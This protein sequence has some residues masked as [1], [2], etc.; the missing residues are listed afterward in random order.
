MPKP[1]AKPTS[2][3]EKPSRVR[4]RMDEAQ[5]E[6]EATLWLREMWRN[7]PAWLASAII[8][9]AL[10]ILLA[11]VL[12]VPEEE[13]PRLLV[14]STRIGSLS[15]PGAHEDP[16]EPKPVEFSDAGEAEPKEETVPEPPGDDNNKDD[17]PFDL[18]E[19]MPGDLPEVL[20]VPPGTK[21][22]GRGSSALYGRTTQ[23]RA[24]LA[25]TEGGTIDSE[26]AV[27][28]GLEWLARH[29]SADGRWR[30]DGF[31]LEGDCD[32]SCQNPGVNSDT[33]GTA[34]GLLPFLGAGQTHHRG[35]YKS[36]VRKALQWLVRA[37][38]SDGDLRSGT[39][40]MYAHGL[41]AIA[42]CEAL[43][44]TRD[45]ELRAPAQLALDFIVKAQHEAGGW[46]YRP[47]ER[48]DT[49]VVGWQLMALRS[50]KLA[51]LDVP[52]EVFE[53][54]NAFLDSVQ[55]RNDAYG[56]RYSYMPRNRATHVMTAEAL[57]CR[58]YA[59]WDRDHPGLVD[60]CGWLLRDHLPTTNR[61]RTN[62]YYWYY[63]TQVMHHMGGD[64]W[65]RWNAHMRNTLVDLQETGGHQ[66]GSWTPGGSHD[67]AGGRLYMT[68]LAVCTLEVYYRHLPLYRKVAVTK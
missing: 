32:R 3:A 59:G 29:Q 23:A 9:M 52:P 45:S 18:G 31:H 46:R 38:Q 24:R 41:A 51:Q 48:G 44:L 4:Q 25:E 64:Y 7:L 17:S 36:E 67:N 13:K 40:R 60:G 2:A 37:Q 11:F 16:A 56:G 47:K 14:L 33:S 61:R 42:L 58:Q 49:S 55:G 30:L 6:G 65:D 26:A 62:M 63:A 28:R 5:T 21:I 43:A 20:T 66:A 15:E 39:G 27:A 12:H 19:E 1:A 50:G 35:K 68:A 34:L 57:L 22:S 53:K 8:H 54:A 10:L